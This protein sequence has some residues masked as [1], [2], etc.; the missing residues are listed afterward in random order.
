MVVDSSANIVLSWIGWH[1]SLHLGLSK[2]PV[3]G[4]QV[5]EVRDKTTM[6]TEGMLDAGLVVVAA[7]ANCV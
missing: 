5:K 3:H 4:G 6:Q 7:S 2:I 1:N